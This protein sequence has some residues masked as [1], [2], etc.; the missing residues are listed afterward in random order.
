MFCVNNNY[1]KR[2]SNS[3]DSNDQKERGRERGGEGGERERGIKVH[4]TTYLPPLGTI[5][6]VYH[7][8]YLTGTIKKH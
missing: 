5:P 7:I 1:V 8:L 4:Q 3:S 2:N 6:H